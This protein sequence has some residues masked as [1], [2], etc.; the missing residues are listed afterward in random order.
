M[1]R[2]STKCHAILEEV[3]KWLVVGFWALVAIVIVGIG[4]IWFYGLPIFALNSMF[5]LN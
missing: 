2:R 1:N 4:T 3:G 5:H